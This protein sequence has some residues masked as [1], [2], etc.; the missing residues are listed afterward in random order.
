MKT[1]SQVI[2][3]VKAKDINVRLMMD[4]LNTR[5][6]FVY[7][8]MTIDRIVSDKNLG[9]DSLDDIMKDLALNFIEGEVEFKMD[10]Q[11][12]AFKDDMQTA[13]VMRLVV[14]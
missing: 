5:C 9:N 3:E 13:E 12:R 14:D 2:E 6:Y 1:F 11:W 7:K 10:I 8:E 4:Q